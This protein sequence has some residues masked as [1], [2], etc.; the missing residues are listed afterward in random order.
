M[1]YKYVLLNRVSLSPDKPQGYSSLIAPSRQTIASSA[2]DAA[3]E[4]W[5]QTAVATGLLVQV[6]DDVRL[7]G[8][9]D[10]YIAM[11]RM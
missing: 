9:R 11:E 5:A 6:I 10:P 7:G 1:F 8:I 4:P 3:S 2:P